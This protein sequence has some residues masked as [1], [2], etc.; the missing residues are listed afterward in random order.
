MTCKQKANAAALR[1]PTPPALRS[2]LL[3]LRWQ[4]DRKLGKVKMV[5]PLKSLWKQRASKPLT[6]GTTQD[7]VLLKGCAPVSPESASRE[8]HHFLTRKRFFASRN[9]RKGTTGEGTERTFDEKIP[10]QFLSHLWVVANHLKKKKNG[11]TSR[12]GNST[13][14][15]LLSRDNEPS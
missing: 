4:W 9:C 6:Q 8:G 11:V 2:K 12:Q 14:L 10:R 1:V 13:E 5:K 7:W 3:S 15:Q